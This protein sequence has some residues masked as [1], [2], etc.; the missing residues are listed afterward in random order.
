[1]SDNSSL[2]LSTSGER[3]EKGTPSFGIS[4]TT[5]DPSGHF[6]ELARTV[7]KS[8]SEE[9]ARAFL[10]CYRRLG[11]A[12][13]LWNIWS[14]YYKLLKNGHK[15]KL[16]IVHLERTLRFLQLWIALAYETDFN[17][18]S[19]QE[20]LN[21]FEDDNKARNHWKLLFLKM[22]KE[23]I[24]RSIQEVEGGPG[25]GQVW[26]SEST[27]Q[28]LDLSHEEIAIALI[29][30]ESQIFRNVRPSEFLC[31]VNWEKVG[32][33]ANINLLIE[34]FNQVSF[35]VTTEILVRNGKAQKKAL[36]KFI[37]I[38][39]KCE[40]MNA[41]NTVMEIMSGLNNSAIQRLKRLWGSISDRSRK[42]F[43]D[44]EEMMSGQHNFRNYYAEIAK[45]PL[46]LLPYFALF[47]R[48]FTF[49][50]QGNAVFHP[51]KPNVQVN[52]ELMRQ[53]GERMSEIRRF[54]SV[55][56]RVEPNQ[57]VLQFLSHL[58]YIEDDDF[59]YQLSLQAQPSMWVNV[60]E[61]SEVHRIPSGSPTVKSDEDDE[62]A[63]FSDDEFDDSDGT[64]S[65][66]ETPVNF[67]Q[68][69]ALT[70]EAIKIK[71][72]RR[73]LRRASKAVLLDGTLSSALWNAILF[74][75]EKQIPRIDWDTKGI[76]TIKGERLLLL[77]ADSLSRDLYSS[78]SVIFPHQSMEENRNFV[79]KY[80][81]DL[82]HTLG[83]AEANFV[84]AK[85]KVKHCQHKIAV[86]VHH[87]A[88]MGWASITLGPSCVMPDTTFKIPFRMEGSFE[89]DSWNSA[90]AT[91][92]ITSDTESLGSGTG[93]QPGSRSSSR[94]S[95]RFQDA[96][97]CVLSSSF[98][99]GWC[100][101]AMRMPL[102]A[103]E[104]TCRSKG[105]L[106]C[107]FLMAHPDRVDDFLLEYIS[108][109]KIPR[110]VSESI[111]IP[112]Y[113]DSRLEPFFNTEMSSP[114]PTSP[115]VAATV[116]KS[117]RPRSKT[118]ILRSTSKSSLRPNVNRTWTSSSFKRGT[119]QMSTVA[120]V[121]HPNNR[122]QLETMRR[123]HKLMEGQGLFQEITVDLK[124]PSIS[125]LG[126]K[127]FPDKREKYILVRPRALSCQFAELI[128]ARM[129][130]PKEIA[131]KYSQ[132][133]LYDLGKSMGFSDAASMSP[134]NIAM[135]LTS[136]IESIHILPVA[137]FRMGWGKMNISLGSALKS[138]SDFCMECTVENSGE[139]EYHETRNPMDPQFY[140]TVLSGYIAGWT[141]N[142]YRMDMATCEVAC[143]GSGHTSCVFVTSTL[144]RLEDFLLSY[145]VSTNRID[146]MSLLPMIEYKHMAASLG[147]GMESGFLSRLFRRKGTI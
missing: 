65:G 137:L 133:F 54:Q 144:E 125:F 21:L 56:H 86:G 12:K 94:K 114:G 98:F 140:C 128:A 82:G 147:S 112:C 31:K 35:W 25:T 32:G 18:E 9:D 20:V 93:S 117:P 67:V 71:E 10:L 19:C 24:E 8:E 16:T 89:V 139:S 120:N 145:F 45:R 105:D 132:Q 75:I 109:E 14:S 15:S 101:S 11:N 87:L 130:G 22:D 4:E 127:S 3:N 91:S 33:C 5:S 135:Q 90:E 63:F 13:D 118:R 136:P 51:E 99:S 119:E 69:V 7:M 121:L 76:S 106:H 80:L 88:Q 34:R 107:T 78:A 6:V 59:L 138:N 27:L 30:L 113:L 57:N 37:S 26:K 115:N 143:R 73:E 2:Y 41:F 83:M 110:E 49:I 102:V 53:F 1:M 17:K 141:S 66:I 116:G 129:D 68:P 103:A 36:E 52:L 95:L 122:E 58:H 123:V 70:P 142:M 126:G 111:S 62:D 29:S 50:Y 38:A 44:L 104:L 55:P 74:A 40:Q 100:A 43:E 81:H 60:L 77:R 96:C 39:K 108:E 131:Y 47:L 48:E 46:P 61:E 84:L 72:E 134:Y 146:D 42:T 124:A 64:P 97:T 92:P 85:L 79:V 23:I 28:L